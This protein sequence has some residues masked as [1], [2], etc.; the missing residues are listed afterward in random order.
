[1]ERRPRASALDF[2]DTGINA[3]TLRNLNSLKNKFAN[4]DSSINEVNHS[5]TLQREEYVIGTAATLSIL[6][7]LS[8]LA[9]RNL[10][11]L[12]VIESQLEE[13]NKASWKIVDILSKR[14]ADR[15]FEGKCRMILF[16]IG[17]ELDSIENMFETHAEWGFYRLNK[18]KNRIT[19]Y[20]MKPD[21]F[22]K[23]SFDEVKI[24]QEILDR[25]DEMYNSFEHQLG[26]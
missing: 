3:L 21:H 19:K 9:D 1:M 8:N 14:E 15:D 2:V 10:S 13:M 18:I 24:A 5:I 17:R 7:K 12:R 23:I 25:V 16:N 22:A 4:L 6:D 20:D 11:Q 26:G